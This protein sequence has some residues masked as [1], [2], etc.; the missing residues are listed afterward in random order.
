MV[1]E[2]G[3]VIPGAPEELMKG[4]PGVGRYTAGGCGHTGGRGCV[5]QLPAF[6]YA[7]VGA[8]ASIAFRKVLL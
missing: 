5:C 7:C 6:C 3:G 2:M 1:S 4:L 8:V